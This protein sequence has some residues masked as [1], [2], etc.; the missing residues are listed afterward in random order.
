MALIDCIEWDCKR[1]DIL[2][3]KYPEKNLTTMTQLIKTQNVASDVA[4]Q[5]HKALRRIKRP[6]HPVVRVAERRFRQM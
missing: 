6:Q 4:R 1:T 2:A 3:W 5:W